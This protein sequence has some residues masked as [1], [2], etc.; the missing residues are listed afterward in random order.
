[1]PCRTLPAILTV[2]TTLLAG[3]AL[4]DDVSGTVTEINKGTG[5]LTINGQ[6]LYTISIP[7]ENVRVGESYDAEYERIRRQVPADQD[8]AE[9]QEPV[10]AAARPSA[11]PERPGAKGRHPRPDP[12]PGRL[13]GVPRPACAAA[14]VARRTSRMLVDSLNIRP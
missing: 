10:G 8:H 6:E 4:A 14:P 13:P 12:R 3:T 5:T 11:R 9:G 7:M 1:M 2:A